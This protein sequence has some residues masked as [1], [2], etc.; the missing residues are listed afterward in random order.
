MK[1]AVK[2]F[3]IQRQLWPANCHLFSS[4]CF[5]EFSGFLCE[6]WHLH[7]FASQL[8]EN[9]MRSWYGLWETI[10]IVS[11][12]FQICSR[13]IRI[14]PEK[15][16]IL[17][18]ILLNHFCLPFVFQFWESLGK[19]LILLSEH[20]YMETIPKT[21]WMILPKFGHILFLMMSGFLSDFYC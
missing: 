8:L 13:T 12:T 1:Y 6:V 10:F 2:M 20:I 4:H 11:S 5:L 16:F 21:G 19:Y 15:L 9:P 14:F 3:W 17:T 18:N 7:C